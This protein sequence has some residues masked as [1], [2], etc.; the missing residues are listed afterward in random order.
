MDIVSVSHHYHKFTTSF[1]YL[2]FVYFAYIFQLHFLLHGWNISDIPWLLFNQQRKKKNNAIG[3][4]ALESKVLTVTS[5]HLKVSD[6]VNQIYSL[7]SKQEH[8]C[9]L[10]AVEI[11][12]FHKAITSSLL[13]NKK[14]T[15]RGSLLDVFVD[16]YLCHFC[17][18]SL[19][20]QS[21]WTCLKFILEPWKIRK[22]CTALHCIFYFFYTESNHGLFGVLVLS[23]ETD[24]AI[25]MCLSKIYMLADIHE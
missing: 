25:C 1:I 20:T 8:L 3:L 23:T 9:N 4:V 10:L 14:P 18:S 15:Q 24:K 13:W 19:L 6:F 16:E 11:Y 7:G 17:S 22:K 21:A 2:L 5:S 12:E